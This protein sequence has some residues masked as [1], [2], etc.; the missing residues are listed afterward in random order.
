MKHGDR[1]QGHRRTHTCAGGIIGRADHH[2]GNLKGIAL[3]SLRWINRRET[4]CVKNLHTA[5][6]TRAALRVL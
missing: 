1:G 5:A 4:A 2:A 3:T 6:D